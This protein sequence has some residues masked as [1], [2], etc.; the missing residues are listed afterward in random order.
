M[1]F[2]EKSSPKGDAKTTL[3]NG[4]TLRDYVTTCYLIDT[5]I[6]NDP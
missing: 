4:V 5:F 2:P 3:R 1:D 6:N